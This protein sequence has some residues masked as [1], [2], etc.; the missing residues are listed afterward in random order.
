MSR[1]HGLKGKP[2]PQRAEHNAEYFGLDEEMLW[3]RD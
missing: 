2:I 3:E 1:P